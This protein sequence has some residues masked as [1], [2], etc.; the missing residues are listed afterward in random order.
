MPASLLTPPWPERLRLGSDP[1]R[2]RT[3]RAAPVEPILHK[4]LQPRARHGGVGGEERP[5]A[6]QIERQ[7]GSGPADRGRVA[8]PPPGRRLPAESRANGVERD[9]S[10]RREQVAVRLDEP[11]LIALTE[12]AAELLMSVVDGLGMH[13][14]ESLHAGSEVRF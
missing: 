4:R 1:G 7:R 2:V 6:D 5:N 13:A 3:G 14:I 9:V 8:A 12:E 11:G 10:E